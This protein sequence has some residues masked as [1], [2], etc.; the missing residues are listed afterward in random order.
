MGGASETKSNSG[1]DS[2][3][4]NL[5]DEDEGSPSLDGANRAAGRFAI[6][7]PG[8]SRDQRKPSGDAITP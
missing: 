2:A 8:K 6:Y 1:K 5:G 7:L 4:P 3:R